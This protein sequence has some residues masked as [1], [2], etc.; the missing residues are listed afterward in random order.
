MNEQSVSLD[1][2][3]S[4]AIKSAQLI[5]THENSVGCD[6]S[7]CWGDDDSCGEHNCSDP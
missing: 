7:V 1:V 5:S 2:L 3:E 4:V 6:G